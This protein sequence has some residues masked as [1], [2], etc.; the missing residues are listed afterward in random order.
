MGKFV[1]AVALDAALG[2]YA[3]A[4]DKSFGRSGIELAPLR[5]P[6]NDNEEIY[7]FTD[8][9]E[10]TYKR[11]PA[12]LADALPDDFG[13]AIIDRYMADKGILQPDYPIDRLAYMVIERWER[14]SLN[15]P[16]VQET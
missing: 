9:P 3:F 16:T 6:L 5:M 11:L 13:N 2:Y 12:L 14:L 1:G 10:A 15:L 7:V 4:Y 8:L